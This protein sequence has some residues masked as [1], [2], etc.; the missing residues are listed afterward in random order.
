MAY[1]Y[2][3]SRTPVP[4]SKLPQ[5]AGL[6]L[7]LY[8][9]KQQSALTKKEQAMQYGTEATLGPKGQTIPATQGTVQRGLE[10]QE[11]RVQTSEAG[12]AESQKQFGTGDVM[13]IRMGTA[14]MISQQVKDGQTDKHL[15]NFDS[16]NSW[17]LSVTKGFDDPATGFVEKP[18]KGQMY[19]YVKS[20]GTWKSLQ[21]Q[22]VQANQ[23]IFENKVKENPE[24]QNTPEA[25]Q[26]LTAIN[27]IGSDDEGQFLDLLFPGVV[28]ERAEIAEAAEIE[29]LKAEKVSGQDKPFLRVVDGQ[30]ITQ[31][32]SG[33]LIAEPIKGFKKTEKEQ[34]T[35][36]ENQ[37]AKSLLDLSLTL[38]G[39]PDKNYSNLYNKY[40]ER[41]SAGMSRE[42]A[43]NEVLQ[44]TS[45]TGE[46][47]YLWS[48]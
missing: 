12:L 11:K 40:R 25:Q 27:Q 33:K 2:P 48:K 19:D 22:V 26:M 24:W 16:I 21:S 31:D 13:R 30:V 42:Q 41:I 45:D 18:T 29:R 1:F 5:M 34:G 39:D 36:T 28:R 7:Q 47:S 17:F 38:E 6:A 46:Y 3:T 23:K 32:K 9:M 8:G 35:L 37:V 10:I 4:E 43:Y 15:K 14:Q 20:P 44:E